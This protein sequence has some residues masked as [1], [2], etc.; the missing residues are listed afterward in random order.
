MSASKTIAHVFFRTISGAKQTKI[1]SPSHSPKNALCELILKIAMNFPP[2][3]QSQP[4]K[5]AVCERAFNISSI[6][7]C[8]E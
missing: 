5:N 6:R 4:E 1:K 7:I 3:T 2:K 8:P